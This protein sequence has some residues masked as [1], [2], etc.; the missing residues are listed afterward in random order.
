MSI[1]PFLLNVLT[2]NKK[3]NTMRKNINKTKK[4]GEEE[5]KKL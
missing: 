3:G 2:Y 5:G 1:S 4:I